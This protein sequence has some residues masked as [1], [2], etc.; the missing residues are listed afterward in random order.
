MIC[1]SLSSISRNL[2]KTFSCLMEFSVRSG[3]S[4]L[5]M[6]FAAEQSVPAFFFGNSQF[7]FPFVFSHC[8]GSFLRK[9]DWI[10]IIKGVTQSEATLKICFTH[11]YPAENSN[12]SLSVC[13]IALSSPFSTYRQSP[14]RVL[15]YQ[16]HYCCL[17]TF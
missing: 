2:I 5:F 13:C 12:A 14:R 7:F 9:G 1:Y 16:T 17:Q 15:P 11:S 3:A 6:L 8:S 4:G 10:K